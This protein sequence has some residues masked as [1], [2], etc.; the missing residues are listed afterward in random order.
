MDGWNGKILRVDLSKGTGKITGYSK[1]IAEKY[2]GGRGLAVK[3]LWD[4]LPP[5]ADPLG[6]ENML[7]FATG[8]YTAFMV[9]NSGKMVV[10][11]KSPLTGGY[12]DGNLGTRA[13]TN[14]APPRGDRSWPM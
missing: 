11:A 3:L 8:P 9:P 14:L 7:I 10:A 6:P 1:D 12:G 4:E 5:G 13:A 2:I